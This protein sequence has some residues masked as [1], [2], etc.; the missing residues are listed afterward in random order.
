MVRGSV[1]L[2]HGTG[3]VTRVLVLCT[4]DKAQEATEAGADT[5]HAPSLHSPS[6]PYKPPCTMDQQYVRW[7][8]PLPFPPHPQSV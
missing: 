5:S 1:T 7:Q 8:I 4:P 3:K 6:C 2:P